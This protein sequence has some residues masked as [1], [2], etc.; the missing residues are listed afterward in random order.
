ME[1]QKYQLETICLFLH[2]TDKLQNVKISVL[3]QLK[4]MMKK[5]NETRFDLCLYSLS[6]IFFGFV[7]LCKLCVGIFVIITYM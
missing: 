1:T 3:D 2:N 4:L 6:C 5:E 7:L